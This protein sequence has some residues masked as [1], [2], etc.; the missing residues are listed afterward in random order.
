MSNY[1]VLHW[2][3]HP[4]SNNDDCWNGFEFDSFEEALAKFEESAPADTAYVQLE[5]HDG[6]TLR[7][8]PA[9]RP[10][11][12]SDAEWRREMAMEAGMLGG[13][14]AYNDFMG[15]GLED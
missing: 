4:N 5:G 10:S 11:R 14:N 12:D 13:V 1:T 15:Y 2:G 6:D 3:S 8:N 7:K 9:F